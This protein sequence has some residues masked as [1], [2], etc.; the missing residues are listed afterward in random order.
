LDGKSLVQQYINKQMKKLTAIIGLALVAGITAQAQTNTTTQSFITSAEQYFSSFNTN[1]NWSGTS[2]E[3]STGYRQVT[4]VGAQ[5]TFD[6]QK[7]LSLF[8]V[9]ASIQFSGIGSTINGAEGQVGY[10]LIQHIDT[11]CDFNIKGGYGLNQDLVK[12]GVI[13]PELMLKKLQTPN[14]ASEIGISMPVYFKGK[15]NNTPTFLVEEVVKF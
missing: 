2:F 13:E 3:I 7:D 14:T 10:A 12:A 6:V 8:N 1:Y 4:G 15:F 9:G 5:N 11:E